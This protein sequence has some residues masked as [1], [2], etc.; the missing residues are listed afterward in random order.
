MFN[1]FA[2]P[3]TVRGPT[4]VSLLCPWDFPGK[5]TGVGCHFLLR[6]IFL[7]RGLNPHLSHWQTNSLPLS[8][9][10]VPVFWLYLCLSVDNLLELWPS[11]LFFPWHSFLPTYPCSN[12]LLCSLAQCS[13]SVSSKPSALLTASPLWVI[14]GI[15]EGAGVGRIPFQQPG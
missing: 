4:P 7:T 11:E 9:L 5:Y 6:G 15:L 1:S 10:G 14:L 2:T 3:W 12:L 8:H 13:Q